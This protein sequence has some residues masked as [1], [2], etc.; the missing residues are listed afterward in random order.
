MADSTAAITK[1]AQIL[2][3]GGL[4][5]FPT[6]TVYGL[7]ADAQN[8][9]AVKKIFAVKGRPPTNPLIVH[10]ANAQ[11][12]QRYTT[13]WPDSA[14]RLTQMFWPGPIT[15]VLPKKAEIVPEVTA[16]RPTVALRAPDH[17]LAQRLLI[18]FDGPVAAPSA[19]QSTR[20]SP[21]LAEHVRHDLG[22][23]VDLILDGAPS[24]VG[25]ES[26]VLDLTQNPPMILRPGAISRQR[27]E[28]LI[29]SVT[30]FTG[31]ISPTEAAPSPGLHEIHYAPLTP[32]FRFG[33]DHL[34]KLV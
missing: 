33:P 12:A 17:V 5:A 11:I 22:D 25:I 18:E 7:G 27:I 24:R 3:S 15:L 2:K 8:A 1:A 10:V 34:E 28:E 30:E 21:S 9:Q 19:N 13:A 14:Q 16:G 32:A 31:T 26:T 23:H 4:V 20:L 29:G 6:E